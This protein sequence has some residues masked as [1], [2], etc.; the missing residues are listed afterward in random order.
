MSPAAGRSQHRN[1]SPLRDTVSHY[2]QKS[3]HLADPKHIEQSFPAFLPQPPL[4]SLTSDSI[5]SST[6][7]VRDRGGNEVRDRTGFGSRLRF[8][9][10]LAPK[11]EDMG[12]TST[13]VGS[14]WS[15]FFFYKSGDAQKTLRHF[16]PVQ[17]RPQKA[18]RENLLGSRAT[19]GRRV[20]LAAFSEESFDEIVVDSSIGCSSA[21]AS[22]IYYNAHL[23]CSTPTLLKYDC[24]ASA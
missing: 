13:D 18:R 12:C 1:L 15:F 3:K 19:I 21:L 23:Y 6:T 10:R 22:D 11:P 17:H 16:L 5:T 4:R 7:W 14:P 9:V 20:F 8:G 24:T 2:S